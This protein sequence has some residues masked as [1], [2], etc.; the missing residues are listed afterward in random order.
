MR[1][2]NLSTTRL[3][4]RRRHAH[5]LF[6]AALLPAIGAAQ[7]QDSLPELATLRDCVRS[8]FPESSFKQAVELVSQDRA[9]GSRT[10]QSRLY[11]EAQG[12]GRFGLMLQVNQPADL[13]GARYLLLERAG[14]DDMYVYLPAVGRTRR[15]IGSM[16]GQPLWGTEFSY[17]DIKQLQGAMIHSPAQVTGSETRDGRLIHHIEVSPAAEEESSYTRIELELDAQTCLVT[18]T[19]LF[20]A[21]GVRKRMS[22]DPTSFRQ[23]GERWVYGRV[24]IDNLREQTSSYLVFSDVEYDERLSNT[25]FNPKSFHIAN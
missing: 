15:I 24:N 16:R 25:L 8:N 11:G 10:L 18:E 19:R 1:Q 23:L 21:A 2:A 20:D 17:E 3:P 9:G 4:R 5:W 14:R 7:A 22:A 6:V 13:A 12:E